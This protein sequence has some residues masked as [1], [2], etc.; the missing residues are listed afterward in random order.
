MY[1]TQL[2]NHIYNF[3]SLRT[4][5]AKATPLRSGDVLAGVCANSYEERIA[6]QIALSNAPL[7]NFLNEVVID[8]EKDDV[9]RLII[10]SHDA[11]AFA[12]IS[13]LTVGEFRDWLLSSEVTNE[14]IHSVANGITPEMAAAV[15]KIMSLQD[16]I[17]VAQKIEVVTKFRTTVGLKGRFSTRL[18]PN[19]PNDD[20][21]GIMAS[22][23]DGLL[24]GCGDAVIGIN[25][26]SESEEIVTSILSM[27]EE[28]R[29]KFEIPMQS[30]VLAHYTL[31]KNILN[32]APVD[33]IFQSIAGTQKANESF[34]V[35]LHELQEANE[36]VLSLN[37]NPVSKQV[38]Y[39]ETGQGTAL[40][41][42]ANAMIDQQ[43]CEAR[44]YAI[45]RK[46]NPFLVNSVVGFIGPEYLYNGKQIIRA[47]LEDHFCG[48]LL[49]LP[50]GIDVCYTN[51][52]DCD[53][54]DMDNLSTLLAAANC[55]FMMAVPGSD[56]IMLQYQSTSYNDA[57]Y[58]RK[59]FNRKPAPEF[60]L[61][62]KKMGIFNSDGELSYTNEDVKKLLNHLS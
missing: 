11:I 9:T 28:L 32:K 15:S 43:T 54:D 1:R 61:W 25:P 47:G 34:G 13:H 57:A 6:A 18:Q 8:Y 23:I 41:A 35:N 12:P 44:A 17:L 5:L 56:D 10:D 39:F 24:F 50:M 40:S 2:S 21:K 26:V 58:V 45:A 4:L 55:N 33:L 27:L 48:K 22:A 19:H 37:R 49:G 60:E 51:H 52:A 62:L 16:L 20:N 3:D 31:T 14:I 29:L 30:C 38:F 36:A 7:K 53:Q 42:N 59:V 46:F